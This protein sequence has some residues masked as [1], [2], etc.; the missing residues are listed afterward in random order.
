MVGGAATTGVSDPD[1]LFSYGRGLIISLTAT[2]SAPGPIGMATP[3]KVAR[4]PGCTDAVADATSAVRGSA[5]IADEPKDARRM[6]ER[7]KYWARKKAMEA[8]SAVTQ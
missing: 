1:K 2:G 4:N 5:A 6:V 3:L 7:A 8:E